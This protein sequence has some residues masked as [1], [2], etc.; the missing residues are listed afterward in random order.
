MY[1]Y[2]HV[3]PKDSCMFFF[4]KSFTSDEEGKDKISDGNLLDKLA[5]RTSE[6][7][8]NNLKQQSVIYKL[9]KHSRGHRQVKI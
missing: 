3:F 7:K 2:S 6:P 5:S 8:V 9:N 1:N 4:Q